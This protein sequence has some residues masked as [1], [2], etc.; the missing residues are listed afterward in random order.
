MLFRRRYARNAEGPAHRA[1][2]LRAVS[3]ARHYPSWK[4]LE[5]L[6]SISRG[7]RAGAGSVRKR[8]F[9]RR[10]GVARNVPKEPLSIGFYKSPLAIRRAYTAFCRF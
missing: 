2:P 3:L 10:I 7:C 4:S 9:A 6:R 8:R 5:D 1:M